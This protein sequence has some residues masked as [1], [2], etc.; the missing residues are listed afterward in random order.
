MQQNQRVI[1]VRGAGSDGAKLLAG[2][3]KKTAPAGARRSRAHMVMI[4]ADARA[5][6]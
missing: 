6:F 3:K 2:G 4:A 1:P 5:A